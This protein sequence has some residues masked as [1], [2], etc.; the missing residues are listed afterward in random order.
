MKWLFTGF[1]SVAQSGKRGF[2]LIAVE[3]GTRQGP[4]LERSQIAPL[5]GTN[6]TSQ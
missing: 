1:E 4:G 3:Q 5:S 2:G 6:N